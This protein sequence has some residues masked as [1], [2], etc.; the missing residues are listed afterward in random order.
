MAVNNN[1]ASLFYQHTNVMNSYPQHSRPLPTKEE[2]GDQ[3]ASIAEK[4]TAE[5]IAPQ[6]EQLWH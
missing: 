4:L 5:L 2:R 1:E 6:L 3:Q